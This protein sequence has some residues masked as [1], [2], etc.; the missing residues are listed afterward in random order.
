VA[1]AAR[2]ALKPR[3]LDLRKPKSTRWFSEPL[4]VIQSTEH[5]GRGTCFLLPFVS[6]PFAAE[7]PTEP[8]G[9]GMCCFPLFDA[10]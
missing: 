6:R 1:H 3:T 8:G 7:D 5:G 9:Q 4:F 10:V 2:V